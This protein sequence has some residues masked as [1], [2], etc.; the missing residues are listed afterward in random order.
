MTSRT[1]EF[2]VRLALGARRG[3]VAWIVLREA[4][5]L[6]LLGV[7]FGLPGVF[8]LARV[9]SSLLFGVTPADPL[10]L[11][12]ATVTLTAVAALAAWLPARRATGVSPMVALR[13]E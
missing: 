11:G 4:A 7:A 5:Q 10:S 3:D 12:L 6:V 2:G 8:V 13:Y 1:V 9:A